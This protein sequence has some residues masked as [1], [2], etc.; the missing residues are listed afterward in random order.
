MRKPPAPICAALLAL[1]VSA[2]C[3]FSAAGGPSPAQMLT[4][5][6]RGLLNASSFHVSGSLTYASPYSVDLMVGG[7]NLDGSVGQGRVPIAVRRVG[8]RVFERGAQ[9]FHLNNQPL[10][11]DAYWVVHPQGVLSTLVETLSDW[12]PLVK[13]LQDS[14]GSVSQVPGP[15]VAG[16]RTIRL[17]SEGLSMLVPENGPRIPLTLTT[18]SGR[19]LPSH[20]YDISLVFDR[21]GAAVTVDVPTAIIDL[22]DHNTLP[23]HDVPD[24]TT[25]HFENCD[26]GGCTLASDFVNSGGRQ[27]SATATF[28]VSHAGQLLT[29]CQLPIPVLDNMQRTRLSCRLNY[30]ATQEVAG[31]VLANNPDGVA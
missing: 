11:S 12:R 26:G 16:R 29:S 17:V 21:Y 10:V 2:A 27:G 9:Y 20:V 31:G 7:G 6:L 5:S 15:L 18:T 8:G 3:S 30:D 14:A 24:L 13:Q 28:R 25:F 4:D 19:Q 23:V 22:D 1:V